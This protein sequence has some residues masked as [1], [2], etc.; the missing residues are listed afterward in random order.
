LFHNCFYLLDKVNSR[1]DPNP[2]P[3]D[4][5]VTGQWGRIRDSP[6]LG[7]DSCKRFLIGPATM[8]KSASRRQQH[9]NRQNTE[10]A[11]SRF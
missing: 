9:H 6:S 1:P 8:A 10:K 11:S 3:P 2:F 7:R 5:D 4:S